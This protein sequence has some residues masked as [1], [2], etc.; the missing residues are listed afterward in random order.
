MSTLPNRRSEEEFTWVSDAEAG[1]TLLTGLK[2]SGEAV[3]PIG[4]IPA[5]ALRSH[6]ARKHWYEIP[7]RISY[8]IVEILVALCGLILT[9]PVT[10]IIA[11]IIRRDSPGPAVF[12]QIRLTRNL[13]P[14]TFYKFRT[15]YAD[16]RQRFPELYSYSYTPEQMASLYFK[17]DSDPRVTRVGKWLRRTTLD[18]IPNLFNLL[19]GEVTMVGPRPEIPEMLPSYRTDQLLKFA[20]KPGLTG[21][22]Q[23]SGR[24]RLTMEETI[25]C[26]LAYVRNRSWRLDLWILMMTFKRVI[27]RDGAL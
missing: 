9:L 24:N 12:R 10:V 21:L 16:A 22:A 26:D 15:L 19:R 27:A 11:W 1:K 18:E 5:S 20:V 17:T 2:V 8:R 14:F 23:V 13:R 6:A 3:W 4:S 7:A 25:A